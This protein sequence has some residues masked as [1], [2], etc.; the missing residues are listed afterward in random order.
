MNTQRFKAQM[1]LIT[2]L[3]I[4][5]LSIVVLGIVSV[6][7][8]NSRQTIDNQI[9]EKVLNAGETGTLTWLEKYAKSATL[10]TG[11]ALDPA[12]VTINTT[13]FQ[14]TIVDADEIKTV[15]QVYDTNVVKDFELRKD[16]NFDIDLFNDATATHYTGEIRLAWQGT[17]ALELS[18]YYG[19]VGISKS[20]VEVLD[21]VNLYEAAIGDSL[22]SAAPNHP[23]NITLDPATGEY[24]FRISNIDGYNVNWRPTFISVV[25]RSKTVNSILLSIRGDAGLPNQVRAFET[26]STGANDTS[27]NK[28]AQVFTQVPLLPPGLS[29]LYSPFLVDGVVN[30]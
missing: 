3:V 19:E 26:V 27:A 29:F 14:C 23:F 25:P 12:C 18:L 17:A 30:K 11:G 20:I 5:V 21:R 22:N 16:S 24:V 7:V 28:V 4:T 2:I 6:A 15:S 10:P 13:K 9:Y 8:Q 1:L